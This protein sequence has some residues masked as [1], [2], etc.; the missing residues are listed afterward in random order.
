ME[1]S[2]LLAVGKLMGYSVSATVN[3][4]SGGRYWTA[5]VWRAGNNAPTVFSGKRTTKA[6]AI[7]Y[8]WECVNAEILRRA[9]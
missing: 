4:F 9:R 2:E 8:G 1:K 6:Q 5:Y 7:T 3:P